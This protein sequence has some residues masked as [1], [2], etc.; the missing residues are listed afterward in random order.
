MWGTRLW[1]RHL[2]G[3]FE[4]G[5]VQRAGETLR[6]LRTSAGATSS[7]ATFR[8]PC[9]IS[10]Y[11]HKRLLFF[12]SEPRLQS[13]L[14]MPL[15]V[16]QIGPR[17]RAAAIVIF[18]VVIVSLS[19]IRS[20]PD[21]I[22]GTRP[23]T[24]HEEFYRYIAQELSEPELCEKISWTA[25]LP[26]GFFEERAYVRSECYEFIAGRTKNP[27]L[28]W[29]VKRYGA[30]SLLSHQT[31]MWSCLDHALHGWS[32]GVGINP[33]DLTAFFTDMGY[34][35]DT[36]HLE[37]ITPPV[38]SVKDLYRQLPKR[39]DILAQIEKARNSSGASSTASLTD[40]EDTAYL[41]DMAALVTKDSRSCMRI[42]EDLP[43]ASEPHKFRDW[44]LMTLA[45]NTKDAD[46]CRRISIP[47]N[48]RDARLSLQ[49]TCLFQ[50]NSPY[51][52]NAVYGPEVPMS[53]EQMRRLIAM[54]KYEVPRA[55]DLPPEEIYQ[56]YSR[57]LDEL[58]HTTDPQHVAA[59]ERFL[60]RV[61]RLPDGSN[62]RSTFL[63]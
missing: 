24:K 34:D 36:L 56:A 16:K 46:L 54:L 14:V 62:A 61:R 30:V 48:T 55:K 51:P 52:S 13:N 9:Q 50:V 19:G 59:R 43:V 5:N 25:L 35:P 63:R 37:G 6:S 10:N 12:Q 17:W 40:I 11:F 60:D 22:R 53:D 27:W 3:G 58:E 32:G 49:A 45:T 29:K 38:V 33:N 26:G 23:G 47:P 21:Q 15:P 2:A 20:W 8:F 28:C 1:R 42:P 44:C 57:F 4:F 31:S 41:D 39:P 18:L 7:R